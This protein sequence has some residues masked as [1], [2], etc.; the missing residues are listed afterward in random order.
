MCERSYF[1]LSK[2]KQIKKWN[3]GRWYLGHIFLY[4]YFK[5]NVVKYCGT[6]GEPVIDN[7]K[8]LCIKDSNIIHSRHKVT[9]SDRKY[10]DHPK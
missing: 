8:G 1:L 7:T 10:V 5:K 2:E 3:A 4:L 6:W 9:D